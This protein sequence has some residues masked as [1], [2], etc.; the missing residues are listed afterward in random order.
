GGAALPLETKFQA[1]VDGSNGDTLLND[2]QAVLGTT[3]L[4]AKGGV[5]HTPRRKGR[6]VSLE[7]A[8]ANGRLEDVLRLAIDEPRP[9]MSGALTLDTTLELPPGE[10]RVADRLALDGSFTVDDLRFA[11]RGIQDK[12]DEFSRRGRGKPTE[13]QIEN[14][15]SAMR[16]RFRLRNGTLSLTGVRFAVRGGLVQLDGKY[17]LRGGALDFRGTVRL[18]ARASQ[19]MTGWKSWVLKPFDPILPKD[20]AGTVL[21]ITIKGTA[22]QR[23]FGVDVKESVGPAA[24]SR[25]GGRGLGLRARRPAPRT[26]ATASRQVC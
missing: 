21:T 25:G 26:A 3:P 13:D 8:I 22:R 2:V 5:V 14:V 12:I 19:T 11:S 10:P 24:R 17:V 20:G 1:I 4:T 23:K 9:P 15:A 16:G 7:V 6:T 18:D